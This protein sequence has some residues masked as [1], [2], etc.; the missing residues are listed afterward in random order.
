MVLTMTY[1]QE[2]EPGWSEGEVPREG[3]QRRWHVNPKEVACE[4]G[5]EFGREEFGVG[6]RTHT[7]TQE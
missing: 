4:P 2:G 7:K 1:P 6:R 5:Q 3:F